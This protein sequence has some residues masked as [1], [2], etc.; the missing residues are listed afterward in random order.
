VRENSC[1]CKVIVIKYENCR[2]EFRVGSNRTKLAQRGC[3]IKFG[4][5][6]TLY[7]K[8]FHRFC[9]E[10]P[11]NTMAYNYPAMGNPPLPPGAMSKYNL[12]S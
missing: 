8:L 5:V 7:C 12:L 11:Q 9:V 2:G 1:A 10:V 3:S 6:L 4:S